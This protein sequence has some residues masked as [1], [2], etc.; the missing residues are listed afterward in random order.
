M[1]I[2]QKIRNFFFPEY[3]TLEK[4]NNRLKRN[5]FLIVRRENTTGGIRAKKRWSDYFELTDMATFASPANKNK[6]IYNQINK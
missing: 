2:K 5:I 1:N 4:E 3:K 6:G